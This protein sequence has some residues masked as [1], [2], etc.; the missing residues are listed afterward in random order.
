MNRLFGDIVK[1]TPSSK[2]VG[3]LTLFLMA[4]GM[5][6]DDLLRLDVN[7]DL[8][9][10]HSVIDLFA[11]SLGTP[12]G[13]WPPRLQKIILRGAEPSKKRP[14]AD[15][16]HA[17]FAK[18]RRFLERRLARKVRHDEVLSYL[19]YPDV[20]LNYLRT[21]QKFGDVSVLP[22]P[23]FFYG[24]QSGEKIAVEIEPG[25][26]LMIK[27][28]T[29]SEP[30]PD[31]HRTVFFELNGQPREAVVRDDSLKRSRSGPPQDQSRRAGAR[32]STVPRGHHPRLCPVG[33]ESGAG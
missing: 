9:L 28:W 15:L 21:R 11:G 27:F 4:K 23:Q 14:G 12:P 30:H 6:P 29:I 17:D 3:D 33:T 13:G 10:P 1:V 7:H 8:A 20:F 19:L 16:P 24:M 2:V 32:G 26:T 18:T 25:K 5:A 22:T 31:G